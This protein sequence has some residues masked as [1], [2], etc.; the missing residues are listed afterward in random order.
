MPSSSLFVYYFDSD[1]KRRA[2][3]YN[4]YLLMTVMAT[5]EWQHRWSDTLPVLMLSSEVS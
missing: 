1:L 3:V 2:D 5:E 4:V